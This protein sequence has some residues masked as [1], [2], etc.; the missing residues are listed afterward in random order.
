MSLLSS[1]KRAVTR[2]LDPIGDIKKNGIKSSIMATV[3]P[4]DVSNYQAN[5][6]KGKSNAQALAA[7]LAQQKM[8]EQNNSMKS[9]YLQSQHSYQPQMTMP[10]QQQPAFNPQQQAAMNTMRFGGNRPRQQY[11]PPQMMPMQPPQGG[12][13]VPQINNGSPMP[14]SGAPWNIQRRFN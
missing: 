5:I 7:G 13:T 9:Q 8:D 1:I 10:I 14:M 12:S 11:N 2:S 6:A 3:D 4:L